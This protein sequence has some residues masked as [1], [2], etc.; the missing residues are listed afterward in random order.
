MALL[1][2]LVIVPVVYGEGVQFFSL[3]LHFLIGQGRKQAGVQAAGEKGSD[4][5]IGYQLSPDSVLYQ[6]PDML[7]GL[8]KGFGMCS[9]M[10]FPIRVQMQLPLHPIAAVCRFDFCHSPEY[11]IAGRAPRPHEQQLCNTGLI[12]F[13]RH[14]RMCEQRFDFRAEYQAARNF[15]VE[16]RLYTNAVPCQKKAKMPLNC[17]TQPGPQ[18]A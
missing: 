14:L 9:R 3:A 4:G 5:H 15:G 2:I 6:L 7:C 11:A 10:Q 16:Q 17:S 13:V 8:G 12:N 1:K 18:L